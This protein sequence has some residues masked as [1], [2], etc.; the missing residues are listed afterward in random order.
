VPCHNFPAFL[1]AAESGNG[2][3]FVPSFAILL[4]P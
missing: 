4:I 3:S 1:A 2:F